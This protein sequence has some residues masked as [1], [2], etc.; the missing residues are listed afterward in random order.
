MNSRRKPY[1]LTN[2]NSTAFWLIDNLWMPLATAHHTQDK[3]SLMEQVCGT[4]IGGPQTHMHPTDEGMYVLEGH[5]TFQVA[6]QELKAGPGTFASIPRLIEHSFTIDEPGTRLLNFYTPGGFE[7]FIISLAVPAAERRAPEPGTTPMPARWM[8]MEASR[9]FGQLAGQTMPVADPPT[10][11]NRVTKASERNPIRPYGVELERAPGYWV[12]G[13]LITLLATKE[14]T[15][16]SYSLLHQRSPADA[17]PALH[18]H[19]QDEAIYLLSGELAL[20]A[21]EE[22]FP[23]QAGSFIYVPAGTVHTFR[24][25]SAEAQLLNWYLPGGF[26]QAVV[27]QGT[28]A[29]DRGLPPNRTG[30]KLTPE[31]RKELLERLGATI[32]AAPDAMQ[33]TGASTTLLG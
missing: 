7:M 14:Q 1:M 26:E 31:Q 23:A 11:E 15:G 19:E 24:V 5:I 17:G 21:G 29:S 9:E 6:G 22:C 13:S 25:S 18:A 12:E 10:D 27:E 20:V 16:G 28:P 4:G 33:A 2:Q 8:A 3:F 30:Q 32:M